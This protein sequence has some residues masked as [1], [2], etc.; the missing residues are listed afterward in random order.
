MLDP[1]YHSVEDGAELLKT[2]DPPTPPIDMPPVELV[3]QIPSAP[4][5]PL[6]LTLPVVGNPPLPPIEPIATVVLSPLFPPTPPGAVNRL[7][8]VVEL[9]VLP[10]EIPPIPPPPPDPQIC[11]FLED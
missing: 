4:D 1:S 6:I 3:I 9:P 5:P 2:L 7:P 10:E 11:L 8:N